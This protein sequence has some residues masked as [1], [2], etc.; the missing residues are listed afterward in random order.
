MV[1]HPGFNPQYF[2]LSNL[3]FFT[4]IDDMCFACLSTVAPL[5]AA[6]SS[7][8]LSAWLDAPGAMTLSASVAESHF[9]CSQGSNPFPA[10]GA[11]E[12]LF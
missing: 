11:T 9:L 5:S 10:R 8:S 12:H 6:H 4:W 1:K 7:A 2:H 3:S